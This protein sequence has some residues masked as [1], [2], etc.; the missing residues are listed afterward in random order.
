M[1]RIFEVDFNLV[2]GSMWPDYHL[3]FEA[4]YLIDCETVEELLY[5]LNNYYDYQLAYIL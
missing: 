3:D 4:E 5:A 1:S 2:D